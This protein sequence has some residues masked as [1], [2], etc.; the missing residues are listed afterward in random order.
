[1]LKSDSLKSLHSK[2]N[3]KPCNNV[4]DVKLI[5][6]LRDQIKCRRTRLN[7]TRQDNQLFEDIFDIINENQTLSGSKRPSSASS[8]IK[9]F[10]SRRSINKVHPI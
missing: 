4:I 6:G 8:S 2:Q 1:M 10:N 5:Q 9:T 7:Q 3:F